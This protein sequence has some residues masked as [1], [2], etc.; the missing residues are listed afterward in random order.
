M[1]ISFPGHKGVVFCVDGAPEFLYA[2][3]TMTVSY[4]DE[5]QLQNSLICHTI[6]I[7]APNND[8]TKDLM[9]TLSE[10]NSFDERIEAG[11]KACPVQSRYTEKHMKNLACS[12]YARLRTVLD[13]DF[14]NI[15][16]L[17]SPIVLLRPKETPSYIVIEENY[18]LDKF[19]DNLTVHYLEGNHVSIIDNK[20]CANIVNRALVD[21]DEQEG[22][23]T[24]NLVTSMVE[25]QRE[26]KA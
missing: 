8:A 12:C 11:I 4:K 25:T 2:L 7:V 21:K 5:K 16:K 9:K 24:Q 19:T 15:K 3:L 23:G 6:D 14:K 13:Y 20:D 1:Y 18:G 10:I 17:Q 26:V 22:K